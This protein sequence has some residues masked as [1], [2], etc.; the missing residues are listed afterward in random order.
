ME[1]P[2]YKVCCRCFTF[3]QAKYITDAMNGFTMQQTSFP[4]VCTIVDDASTDGEQEVIRKYVEENFD[5]SDGS[6][7][8]I[9]ETDYAHIA[10]A[11]HKTNKN[12]YFA[13]LYLKENHYYQHKPKMGYLSE[14]RDMCE[15]E[16]VCEGDDYWIDATKLEK[17]ISA[18][19]NDKSAVFSYSSFYTVDK[20][21]R[22]EFRPFFDKC[23]KRS[24]SGDV[25]FDLFTQNFIMTLTVV[26]RMSISSEITYFDKYHGPTCDY[27]Q[28]ML[29]A[30]KGNAIFFNDKMGCYRNNPNGQ[31]NTNKE[32]IDQIIWEIYKYFAIGVV[33]GELTKKIPLVTN[34][35]FLLQ[36]TYRALMMYLKGKDKR[37]VLTLVKSLV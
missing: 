10:Y 3:N 21:G 20:S 7:A 4:F 31:I 8:F 15:Y 22:E 14:W 11:Q 29:F 5:F 19:E 32:K 12:C 35:L 27:Y 13:V 16:A 34:L 33:T 37:F 23:I 1:Y 30:T 9:K 26:Y 25:L 18:L 36:V 6:V 28:F 17:Q 24:H 2:R